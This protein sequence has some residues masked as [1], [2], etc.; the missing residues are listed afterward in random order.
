M[1][2]AVPFTIKIGAYEK[3]WSFNRS[4]STF[5][6]NLFAIHTWQFYWHT[7]RPKRF[8]QLTRWIDR[9]IFISTT[10]GAAW[11]RFIVFSSGGRRI[12]IN[13]WTKR[14]IFFRQ[15]R[16]GSI[17]DH[18]WLWNARIEQQWNSQLRHWLG[19]FFGKWFW[20]IGSARRSPRTNGGIA[21]TH[22]RNATTT[23]H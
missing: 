16:F 19:F 14:N 20:F 1:E 2:G 17:L 18:H 12:R 22:N 5:G 7:T 21:H 8:Q 3:T 13:Q 4:I 6:H 10:A 15:R 9:C 23:G 11:P